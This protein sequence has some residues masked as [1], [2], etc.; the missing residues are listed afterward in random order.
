MLIIPIEHVY[1][2]YNLHIKKNLVKRMGRN[3]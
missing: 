3:S 2:K 1:K